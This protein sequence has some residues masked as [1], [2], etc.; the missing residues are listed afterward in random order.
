MMASSNNMNHVRGDDDV[1]ALLD[2][3]TS[4]SASASGIQHP[5][6]HQGDGDGDGWRQ[7]QPQSQAKASS[8]I[9]YH[10]TTLTTAHKL[11]PPTSPHIE[12]IRH[13]CH[14]KFKDNFYEMF[15][16]CCP[17]D[18][19]STNP[20]SHN[21]NNKQNC[22]E[23]NAII[24]STIQSVWKGMPPHGVWERFQFSLKTLEARCV[25]HVHQGSSSGGSG[26]GSGRGD[27]DGNKSCNYY[28]YNNCKK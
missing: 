26:S 11:S 23:R 8:T 7:H 2:E 6:A 20:A 9:E 22:W 5:S 19:T 27:V 10:E 13:R 21:H 4:A 16:A 1:L 12:L 15:R 3:M 25:Q 28:N 24:K 18:S 14:E 17:N